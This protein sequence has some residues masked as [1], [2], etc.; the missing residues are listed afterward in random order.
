MDLMNTLSTMAD[1]IRAFPWSETELGPVEGWPPSLCAAV[2]LMLP[3]QAQI[4]IFAGADYVALYND[5]Y[6]P[7]IGQKHPHALG[8]PAREYWAELWSDLEPLL[9]HVRQTGE[10]VSAKDRPF[11]IHRDILPETVYFDISY[12]AIRD[13]AGK[14]HSVFCI[15]SETTERVRAFATESRLAAIVSSS[16]DAI[17]GTDTA[18][19]ITDWNHGAEQLYGYRAEE[20][21]GRS[22]TILVPAHRPHEEEEIMEKILAGERVE[23]HETQRVC[24]DGTLKDVSL[25]VSPIRDECGQV[26]GASKIARDIS[27]RKEAERLQRVLMG[28]LKHRVKNILANVQAIARQTFR[29]VDPTAATVFSKRLQSLATAHDLL[30]QESWEGARISTVVAKILS[31]YDPGRFSMQGTDFTIPPR[32]V[33]AISL[34]LHELATNAVKYGALKAPEGRVEISWNRT[35]EEQAGFEL[36]W[37]ERGGPAVTPPAAEGFGSVLIRDVLAAELGGEVELH[38]D[39]EGL[40]CI[41]RAPG[42]AEWES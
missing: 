38:Y 8:R 4:V 29:E 14:V 15:V 36:R 31:V 32:V 20:V 13:P 9:A 2:E 6:A 19:C 10:T 42:E 12:S 21:I 18:Q 37:I 33:V 35:S 24:K 40:T 34:A 41:V 25:T 28:E 30:T 3:A 7:T 11:Y 1:R 16:D 27:G 26:V 23:P 5:A 39:P 22:V 17:L